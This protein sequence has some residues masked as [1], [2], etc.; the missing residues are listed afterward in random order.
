VIYILFAILYNY[1]GAKAKCR[2]KGEEAA[3]TIN[4]SPSKLSWV[5]SLT[6]STSPSTLSSTTSSHPNNSNSILPPMTSSKIFLVTVFLWRN[7]DD[8]TE[9]SIWIFL[10]PPSI[11]KN[12]VVYLHH[13]FSLYCSQN[14][15]SFASQ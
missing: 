1:K 12:I 6:N 4:A 9:G 14:G 15:N 5:S 8:H 2:K 7:Q 11:K 13:A 3:L 10:L